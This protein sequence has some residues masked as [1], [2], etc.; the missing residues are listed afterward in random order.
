[1]DTVVVYVKGEVA[2]QAFTHHSRSRTHTT[3]DFKTL[4]R[5]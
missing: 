2:A 5:T 4:Q 3:R 1:M